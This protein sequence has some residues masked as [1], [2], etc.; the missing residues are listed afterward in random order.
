M[1]GHGT[2]AMIT[3]LWKA[4]G[5]INLINK[6]AWVMYNNGLQIHEGGWNLFVLGLN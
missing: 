6:K 1:R 5:M 3:K 4:T 2:A